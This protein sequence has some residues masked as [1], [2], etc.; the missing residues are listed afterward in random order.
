FLPAHPD[1]HFNLSHSGSIMALAVTRAGPVGV[2]VERIDASRSMEELVARNFAPG[3][4][5][6]FLALPEGERTDAFFEIWT[7]KEAFL[8]VTGEG[9][10][11]GLDSFE[12]TV[13][14]AAALR[15]VDGRPPGARWWMRDVPVPGGYRGA[16]VVEGRPSHL[17][18]LAAEGG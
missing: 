11:R 17:H 9:L 12:V 15:V 16:V 6:A 13:A 10:F 4:Q 7:R 18:V 14:S 3:E 1:L 5:A 8:K 2:D